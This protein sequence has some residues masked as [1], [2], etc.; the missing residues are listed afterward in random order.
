MIQGRLMM[1]GIAAQ[2][3]PR[4]II[5]FAKQSK[6]FKKNSYLILLANIKGNRPSSIHRDI[7]HISFICNCA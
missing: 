4:P 6:T 3:P 1:E 5:Y 2:K 7:R